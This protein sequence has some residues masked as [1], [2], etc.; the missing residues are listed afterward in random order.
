MKIFKNN[1]GTVVGVVII[2]T[3]V[4]LLFPLAFDNPRVYSIIIY[5]SIA[6]LFALLL[7]LIWVNLFAPHKHKNHYP[8]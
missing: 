6:I 5:T 3:S 8:D 1:V 7:F 4:V 2:L